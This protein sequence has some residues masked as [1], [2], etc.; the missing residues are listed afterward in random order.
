MFL[1]CMLVP[2]FYVCSGLRIEYSNLKGTVQ[3]VIWIFQLFSFRHTCPGD[4][5][6]ALS[7][8]L[9]LLICINTVYI[10]EFPLSQ[11]VPGAVQCLYMGNVKYMRHW[12][13]LLCMWDGVG[14][15]ILC[16]AHSTVGMLQML[17]CARDSLQAGLKTKCNKMKWM[18]ENER[19]KE[20]LQEG[21]QLNAV[22]CTY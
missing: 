6:I 11:P 12:C 9:F 13:D 1:C 7:W 8:L 18:N 22:Q 4:S 3:S 15:D 20:S 2:E 10:V 14:F 5:I 16:W 21:K 19:V 17:C